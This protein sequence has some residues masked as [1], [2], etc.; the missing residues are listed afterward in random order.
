MKRNI[1]EFAHPNDPDDCVWIAAPSLEDAALIAGM[2]GVEGEG[3]LAYKA[4]QVPQHPRDMRAFGVD[5][6]DIE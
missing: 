4:E 1:Y 6:F 3:V 5:F 2:H